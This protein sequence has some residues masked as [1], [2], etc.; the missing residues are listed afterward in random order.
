MPKYYVESGPVKLV[1]GATNAKRAAVKAFQWSCD[2]QATIQAASP[3]EHVQA[4][5]ELG[6]QLHDTIR[7]GE[8]GFGHPD[9]D[10]FDTLDVVAIWQGYAFPWTQPANR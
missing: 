10:V 8:Q 6:W 5:E 2:R 7:V 3:L 9:S 4:A 1:I